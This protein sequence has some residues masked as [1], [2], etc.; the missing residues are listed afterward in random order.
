[1]GKRKNTNMNPD[2]IQELANDKPVV[3]KILNNAGKNIYTGSAKR[4]RVEDRIK[5]HL[6]GG[7]DPIRG[8]RRVLIDQKNS[9][10]EAEDSESRIIKRS[11]PKFNKLGK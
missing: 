8:G 5:E 9:I 1:M 7:K 6:L 3:Y 2:D 11:K 10:Q 4:G